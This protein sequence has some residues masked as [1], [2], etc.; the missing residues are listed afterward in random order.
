MGSRLGFGERGGEA[1]GRGVELGVF[2]GGAVAAHENGVH[3]SQGAA[4]AEGEAEEEADKY[5]PI[6]AHRS[7]DVTLGV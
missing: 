5:A 2:D 3:D 7:H 4:D 6:T 1:L